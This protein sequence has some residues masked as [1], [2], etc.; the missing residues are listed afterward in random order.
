MLGPEERYLR[1]TQERARDHALSGSI[2]EVAIFEEAPGGERTLVSRAVTDWE[3]R[4][5][6]A[7]EDRFVYFP[8]LVRTTATDVPTRRELRTGSTSPSTPTTRSAT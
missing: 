6:F 4:E 2:R 3:V 7:G 5:E 1:T 8:H